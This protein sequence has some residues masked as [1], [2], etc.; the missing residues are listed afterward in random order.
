MAFFEFPHTRTYDSDLGWL[1]KQVSSYEET[2]SAFDAW[3][4]EYQPRIEDLEACCAALESGDLPEGVQRG[5]ET[6]LRKN[7][8]T[9]IKEII[10]NVWFGL[11][12]A[13]YF[14]AY[15]PE[16]WRDIIFKTT[17]LDIILDLQP[18]YGHLVLQYN[19]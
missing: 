2:I 11:T 5:I 16:S 7:G 4:E 14:V 3:M 10:K 13:G 12:D 1:I 17:G 19:I 8:P 9:I 18:E 15:V 6:W